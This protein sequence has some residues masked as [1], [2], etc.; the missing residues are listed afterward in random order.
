MTI[1]ACYVSPE[2]VVFGSDSTTTVATIDNVTKE[3]VHHQYDFAQKIFQVGESSTLGIV[4]WGLA[5]LLDQS[6][7]MVIAQFADELLRNPPLPDMAAVADRWGEFF[8]G[9]Y[10]AAYPNEIAEV[11]A[12]AQ[13][14]TRNDQEAERYKVL[15]NAFACGFCIGGNLEHDRKPKAMAVIFDPEQATPP[16]HQSLLFGRPYFWGCPNI[17]DRLTHGL[18]QELV[19]QILASGRWT[20]DQNDLVGLVSLRNL[21]PINILP[22]REAIDY[23]HASVYITIKTMRYSRLPR[24]CGGPVELA[25]ITADRKFRWV[26]HKAFDAAI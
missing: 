19:D 15:R 13:I 12:L 8:W 5:T 11:R 17:M 3:V 21:Y 18:D 1:A 23:V 16:K 24:I 26:R 10:S 25:V 4:T 14:P 7:R 20:G 2:G 22:I 9:P 6:L